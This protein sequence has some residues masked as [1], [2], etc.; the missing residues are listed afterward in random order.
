VLGLGV[1]GWAALSGA[2]LPLRAGGA[3]LGII[4]AALI[5]VSAFASTE[6][7]SYEAF[8]HY[9][10]PREVAA[11]MAE[12]GIPCARLQARP[13]DRSGY[14][15]ALASCPVRADLAIDDGFDDATIRMWKDADARLDWQEAHGRRGRQRSCG[16]DVA[17]RV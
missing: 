11:A 8:E 9:D 3:L 16:A 6:D 7:S 1:V 14:F 10:S 12:G 5:A 4:G 2:R 15:T 17:R 13:V